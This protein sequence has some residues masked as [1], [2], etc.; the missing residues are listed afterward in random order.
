M[1]FPLVNIMRETRQGLDPR[2]V[3]EF[4]TKCG[5]AQEAGQHSEYPD[6]K[7]IDGRGLPKSV[8][9]MLRHMLVFPVRLNSETTTSVTVPR[10]RWSASECLEHCEW[11]H[12]GGEDGCEVDAKVLDSLVDSVK[13]NI[14]QKAIIHKVGVTFVGNK[15]P[16]IKQAFLNFDVDNDGIISLQDAIYSLQDLGVSPEHA[17]KV[18]V[19]MDLNRDGRIDW[20]EF[21]SSAAHCSGEFLQEGLEKVF[22]TYA[23]KPT[24]PFDQI[25]NNQTMRSVDSLQNQFDSHL[26]RNVINVGGNSEDQLVEMR[27]TKKNRKQFVQEVIRQRFHFMIF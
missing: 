16:Q 8:K 27:L 23:R 19:G 13:R 22:K 3:Q 5:D 15:M 26:D 17:K 4:F 10:K 11:L 21:V 14:F 2:K 9:R 12:E 20:S 25:W 6:W 18:A 24:V 1:P 7:L